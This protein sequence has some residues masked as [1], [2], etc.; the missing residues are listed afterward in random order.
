MC[1]C[2]AI[3]AIGFF[4]SRASSSAVDELQRLWGRHYSEFSPNDHHLKPQ[5]GIASKSRESISP[6]P[7]SAGIDRRMPASVNQIRERSKFLAGAIYRPSS[8]AEAAMA[9]GP[10]QFGANNN[11]ALINLIKT[12]KGA[13]RQPSNAAG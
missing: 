1:R 12:L 7:F 9:T 5:S 2:F 11:A 13:E 8:I 10:M 3:C 6:S 4:S